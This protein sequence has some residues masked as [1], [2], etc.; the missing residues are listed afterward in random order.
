MILRHVGICRIMSII[1]L[2]RWIGQ[3]QERSCAEREL[4]FFLPT[5]TELSFQLL[6]TRHRESI[7]LVRVIR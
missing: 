6:I 3:L 5:V 1:Y 4:C 7:C 2:S